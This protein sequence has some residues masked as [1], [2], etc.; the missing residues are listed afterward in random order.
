VIGWVPDLLLGDAHRMLA[1]TEV[2][3]RVLRV[4]GPDAP[5]HLRVLAELSASD[6]GDFEFFSGPQW[7]TVPEAS[8]Q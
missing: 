2:R 8:G 6:L 5:S 3:A 4:N 1:R 7:R